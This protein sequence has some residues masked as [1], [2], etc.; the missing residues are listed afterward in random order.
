MSEDRNF[1]SDERTD[2]RSYLRA[3]FDLEGL[4]SSFFDEL[5]TVRDRLGSGYV[6]TAVG[7]VDDQHAAL[8]AAAHRSRMMQHVFHGDP[9]R[10]WQAEHD[11]AKRV[12]HENHVDACLISQSC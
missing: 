2:P 1:C 11:H 9:E 5:Q 12:T 4:R 3:T 10:V 8:H 6:V 7:H